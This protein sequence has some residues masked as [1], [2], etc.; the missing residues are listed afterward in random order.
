[1]QKRIETP[2]QA[3]AIYPPER[4]KACAQS[5]PKFTPEATPPPLNSKSTLIPTSYTSPAR[6]PYIHKKNEKQFSQKYVQKKI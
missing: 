4:S 2:A 6:P 1:M 5:D 3:H